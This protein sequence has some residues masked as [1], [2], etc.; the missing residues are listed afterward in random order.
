MQH[1]ALSE[2]I[3]NAVKDEEENLTETV[4]QTVEQ[5]LRD[6]YISDWDLKYTKILATHEEI[7]QQIEQLTRDQNDLESDIEKLAKTRKEIDLFL[8]S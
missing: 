6:D 5:A 7:E 4:A 8:N 3:S 2:L 1:L